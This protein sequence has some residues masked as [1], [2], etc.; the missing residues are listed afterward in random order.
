MIKVLDQGFIELIDSMGDDH[1]IC[2]AARTSYGKDAEH[3]EEDVLDKFFLEG[4][5]KLVGDAAVDITVSGGSLTVWGTEA[6]ILYEGP[7]THKVAQDIIDYCHK[8]TSEWKA[9][10]ETLIRRLMRDRHTSPFEMVEFV[11]CVQV[12]MDCWR[13]WIRHRTANVN[14]Y[15]TRYSEALDFFQQTDEAGWRLQAQDNKQGSSGFVEEWPEGYDVVEQ[16][17]YTDP[18]NPASTGKHDLVIKNETGWEK[19]RIPD[20]DKGGTPGGYL[21]NQESKFQSH[22]RQHY[23]ELLKFGVARE[24]ARKDLPLSTYTRAYWKCD[25]HNIFNFLELR[26]DK[27]AQLEIRTYANA[28]A[29]LVKQV[30][31]MAFQAFLDYRVNAMKLSAQEIE[32]IAAIMKENDLYWPQGLLEQKLPNKTEREQAILK[33]K[34]L[35]VME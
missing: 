21:S 17:N 31:P 6:R 29:E 15:S 10:D 34:K 14:E 1:F 30:C 7:V 19:R 3:N 23:Q 18:E 25:L 20:P 13:Q 26:M 9:K 4:A 16:L 28:M 24:Q 32:F 8:K 5:K 33:L 22:A 12:P 35:G 11:F 2:R 27:H